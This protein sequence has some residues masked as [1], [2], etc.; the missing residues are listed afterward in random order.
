VGDFAYLFGMTTVI[1]G[2]VTTQPMQELS[3]LGT[4]RLATF[5][6]VPPPVAP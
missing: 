3:A 4:V 1:V 6:Q 2:A 5:P